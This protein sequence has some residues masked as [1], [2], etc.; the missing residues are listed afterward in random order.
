M[1]HKYERTIDHY[2]YVGANFRLLKELATRCYVEGA[3]LAPSSKMSTMRTMLNKVRDACNVVEISMWKN[4]PDLSNEYTAVF[5]GCT[6][7]KPFGE[8]DKEVV[9]IAAKIAE[10]LVWKEKD[11]EEK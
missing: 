5:D 1:K 3:A 9:D 6:S 7:K 10:S 2:K 8:I 4:H 11:S